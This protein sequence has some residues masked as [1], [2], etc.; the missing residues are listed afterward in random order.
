MARIVR[1]HRLGGP[2][3]LQ[4]DSLE[5]PA[6]GA[7]EVRINVKALGLNRAE[8]M[9]RSGQY[10]EQPVFPSK[11]GYEAAGVVESV[12]PGVE[13][14]QPGDAVST[15][16]AFSQGQY[17][18]Y[19]DVAVVPAFAT[20]RHPAV[21]SWTEAAALWMQYLTAYGAL[22]DIAGLTSGDTLLIP[23]AS[24]SVGIAAIQIANLV[25]ATPVAL[26]RKDDKRE[27]LLELGAAH[28]I[29]TE[30]QDIAA[31]VRSLAGGKGA[32]VVFDPVGGSTIARLTA[33]MAER[34]ILFL[35]GALSPEPTP[36]PLMDVLGKSLTIRGYLLFEITSDPA[37]L[38]RGKE[39]VV[40][41][42]AAGKLKP[43]LA[44][45]FTLDEIVEAHRYL[46][47]N[48]QIGKIVVV[49]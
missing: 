4:I 36:V 27:A 31:E 34:G 41:G 40:D 15:I 25:G 38:E 37:R 44:K 3:V 30:T 20:A 21:L 33:A 9:F 1:F 8:A 47:S 42:I 46:E 39:W 26:T 5:A 22:I 32:R 49:V 29:V 12:G 23:A 48:R 35:Y 6:P 45:T 43:V 19:G 11:L 13:G 10:L 14:F 7:G 2:E 18:V 24:S 17:G 16:P 28:V